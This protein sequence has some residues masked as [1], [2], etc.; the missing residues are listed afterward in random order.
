MNSETFVSWLIHSDWYLLAVWILLLGAAVV[1]CFTELPARLV[2]SRNSKPGNL[3]P[4]P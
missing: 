3:P 1:L 4:A 2:R